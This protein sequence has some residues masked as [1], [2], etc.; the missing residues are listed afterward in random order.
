[1][2]TAGS[3]GSVRVRTAPAGSTRRTTA[4][5]TTRSRGRDETVPPDRSRVP[6]R[7]GLARGRSPGHPEGLLPG[8]PGTLRH[9]LPDDLL[10]QPVARLPEDQVHREHRGVAP[11][12]AR[13]WPRLGV[14]SVRFPHYSSLRAAT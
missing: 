4:Y 6:P 10:A 7:R 14:A 8:V 13:R 12:P 1:G 2:T 3:S 9:S 5:P 11:W